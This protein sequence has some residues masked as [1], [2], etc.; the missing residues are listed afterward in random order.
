MGHAEFRQSVT[1]SKYRNELFA[2]HMGIFLE[3]IYALKE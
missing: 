3:R 2:C 1:L